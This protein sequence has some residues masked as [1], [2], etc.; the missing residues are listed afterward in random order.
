MEA[1]MEAI[2]VIDTKC[3]RPSEFDD[4]S[5]E[6]GR[7]LFGL[8]RDSEE[9]FRAAVRQTLW[10]KAPIQA[11]NDGEDLTYSFARLS[12]SRTETF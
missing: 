6:Q 4:L 11:L 3:L 5:T 1:Q 12:I 10:F 7:E 2:A 9:D 8:V